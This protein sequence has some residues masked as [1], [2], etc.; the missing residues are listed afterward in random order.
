MAAIHKNGNEI[1]FTKKHEMIRRAIADFVKKEI[2]PN[3]DQWEN[4]GPA[5]Y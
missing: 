3:L 5:R 4:F 2:N 1:C